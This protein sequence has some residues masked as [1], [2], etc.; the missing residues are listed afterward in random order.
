MGFMKDI[1]LKDRTLMRFV[2]EKKELFFLRFGIKLPL[3]TIFVTNDKLD[4]RQVY[5]R[6]KE[7]EKKNFM[8][9]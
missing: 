5:I 3:N 4:L 1:G 7:N 2:K 8:E 6:F 9:F